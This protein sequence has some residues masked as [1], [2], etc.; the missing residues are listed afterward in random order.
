MEHRIKLVKKC[1]RYLHFSDSQQS[2]LCRVT[3]FGESQSPRAF[4]KSYRKAL[5]VRILGWNPMV[6]ELREAANRWSPS[7]VQK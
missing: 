2:E 4:M 5:Q 7:V 1:E 3:L 6:E